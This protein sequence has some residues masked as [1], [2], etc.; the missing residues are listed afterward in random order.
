MHILSEIIEHYEMDK[1]IDY[2]DDII[3]LTK[4]IKI[5]LSNKDGIIKYDD[6]WL[7]Y[8]YIVIILPTIV[9]ICIVLINVF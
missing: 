9:F 7:F 8:F 2:L 3:F 6:F 4:Q 1:N 5:E